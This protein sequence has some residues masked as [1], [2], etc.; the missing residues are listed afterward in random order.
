MINDD[1]AILEGY[2]SNGYTI[3]HAMASDTKSGHPVL[4]V[5]LMNG[6][7]RVTKKYRG[8]TVPEI[9]RFLLKKFPN[10]QILDK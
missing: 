5:A 2:L 7:K 9:K 1:I 3:E 10:A 6:G 4:E 8:E